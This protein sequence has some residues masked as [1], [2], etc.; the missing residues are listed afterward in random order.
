M[1]NLIKSNIDNTKIYS[2]KSKDFDSSVF[3]EFFKTE[4][5][6]I[7]EKK[8]YFKKQSDDSYEVTIPTENPKSE[9]LYENKHVRSGLSKGLQKVDPKVRV[10][11]SKLPSPSINYTGVMV[12]NFCEKPAFIPDTYGKAIYY[13]LSDKIEGYDLK[14]FVHSDFIKAKGYCT[15]NEIEYYQRNGNTFEKLTVQ[16]RIGDKVSNYYIQSDSI[17]CDKGSNDIRTTYYNPEFSNKTLYGKKI[18]FSFDGLK[19]GTLRSN[20]L[21]KFDNNETSWLVNWKNCIEKKVSKNIYNTVDGLQLK[22]N[23]DSYFEKT[24]SLSAGTYTFSCFMRLDDTVYYDNGI[25]NVNERKIVEQKDIIDFTIN[26]KTYSYLVNT[27]WEKHFTTFTIDSNKEYTLK[28][29]CNDK[30]SNLDLKVCGLMLTNT[31]YPK[32]YNSRGQEYDQVV[33]NDKTYPLNVLFLSDE[34]IDPSDSWTL[35]YRRKIDANS[36]FTSNVC[37]CVDYLGEKIKFGYLNNK[38]FIDVNGKY[39]DKEININNFINHVENIILKYDYERKILTYEVRSN[40]DKYVFDNL[41]VSN[42]SL[43][44]IM[45]KD[46]VKYNLLF[47]VV[48]DD[49][50]DCLMSGTYNDLMIFTGLVSNDDI[51][52]IINNIMTFTNGRVYYETYKDSLDENDNVVMSLDYEVKDVLTLVTNRIIETKNIGV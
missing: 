35:L 2:L 5:T 30:K 39:I 51:Y 1:L 22:V 25:E 34:K 31:T 18:N 29:S 11:D 4:D 37:L 3:N 49:G 50:L 32:T 27:D 6:T 36:S 16:P 20:N 8:N 38:A 14:N 12:D 15:T 7:I 44:G 52:R 46:T 45:P 24:L 43:E 28:L 48:V 17:S 19:P 23:K 26:D 33:I 13:P 42:I 47:N 41:D 9:G 10:L 21:L 40:L